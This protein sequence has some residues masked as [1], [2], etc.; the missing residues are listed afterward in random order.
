MGRKAKELKALQVERLKTPG[1]HFVGG[2]SGLAL[3]VTSHDVRSWILRVMVAGKRSDMG[4]GSYPTV[5]LAGAK[6]AARAA[7]AKIN[8]GVNPIEERRSMK[9]ALAAARASAQTFQH[10]AEAYIAAKEPG[11]KNAKHGDQWRNTLAAYA[12]P[13]I[14]KLLVRDV[15]QEHIMKI[16]EPMWTTK[17]ETMTRLRGRIESV[18]DWAIARR[19]RNG[20]NPARW[21]GHLDVLLASPKKVARVKN[22]AALPYAQAGA[23]MAALKQTEGMGARALEFAILTAARSGEVRGA[24][25]SEIDFNTALSTIPAARMKAD[26]EHIVPLSPEAVSL[27]RDLK[28]H[29]VNDLLFPNSKG[30]ALSDMTLTAAIRRMNEKKTTAEGAGWEDIYGD[31]IT[32]HGFRSTFRDWAGETTAYPREVIEHALAH[33]LKDKAEAAYARGTLLDKRRRLMADWSKYCSN[34]LT[35][36]TVVPI[37]SGRQH[38]TGEK[39][40]G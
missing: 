33:Q 27:I 24:T 23:F 6:E 22:H 5:T 10:C 21:K 8:A 4:L 12:Y 9:S 2:V 28:G 19:Y 31:T 18:L 25:V 29:A 30:T 35:P 36:G 40:A 20:D 7:R 3:Q 39:E 11:W 26:K 14:G 15:A 13:V 34:V 16:L 1:L 17:T 32:A 38:S 37:G